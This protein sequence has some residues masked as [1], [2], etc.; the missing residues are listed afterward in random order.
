MLPLANRLAIGKVISTGRDQNPGEI[1]HIHFALM[2]WG[3]T[4]LPEKDIDNIFFMCMWLANRNEKSENRVP[5][6]FLTFAYTK[7][8]LKKV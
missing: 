1:V 4:L 8:P 6:G 5:V 3:I 7:M 2:N